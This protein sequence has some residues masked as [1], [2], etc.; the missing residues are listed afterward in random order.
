MSRTHLHIMF[1]PFRGLKSNYTYYT[2][3]TQRL[4]PRHKGLL[5]FLT[6]RRQKQKA[7]VLIKHWVE[8][9]P[10]KA[11]PH[12]PYFLS[13]SA[14]LLFQG[15][16]LSPLFNCSLDPFM[17]FSSFFNHLDACHF[18]LPSVTLSLSLRCSFRLAPPLG[19]I[20]D[21]PLSPHA[22]TT[23]PPPCTWQQGSAQKSIWHPSTQPTHTSGVWH[24]ANHAK[25]YQPVSLSLCSNDFSFCWC[26]TITK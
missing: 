8:L 26:K 25:P 15:I 20:K 11:Y 13:T 3:S 6:H 19:L 10:L 17:S 16:F 9:A 22:G 7:P 21:N 18:L 23:V 1:K 24:H 5:D 4:S 2:S 12:S 14:L